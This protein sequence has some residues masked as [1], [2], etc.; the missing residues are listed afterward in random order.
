MQAKSN[1]EE[2]QKSIAHSF[3]GLQFGRTG[4]QTFIC[5]RQDMDAYIS[6]KIRNLSLLLMVLV[7]FIHGYNINLRFTDGSVEAAYSLRFFEGF[8]S[9]GICRVAVPM[10]FAISGFLATVSLG[11]TFHWKGY[12]TLLGKRIKSLLIPYLLVSALGIITVW[13]LLVIPFSKPF[14]NNYS[15]EYTPWKRWI[16]I[17]TLSPVPYPLWF[18]R[19]LMD[20]FLCFPILFFLI[21]LTKGWIL[22]PLAGLW[23]Y[24]Q[25]HIHLTWIKPF[26]TLAPF[27]LCLI[28]GTPFS[29][30]MVASKTEL[31]GLFFFAL[32]IAAALGPASRVS[33]QM[34][35]L[36]FWVLFMA[37]IGWVA[38][39]TSLSL[40]PTRDHYQVHYHLVGFT[41]IG[42]FIFWFLYDQ[43]HG[44]FIRDK[45]LSKAA[46]FS[47]GLFLFHEP[48][49]TI[50]KKGMIRFGGGGDGI[51]W[52]AFLIC[53]ILS[54]LFSFYLSFFLSR[55][56]PTAYNWL[57]G[58]RRPDHQKTPI[59]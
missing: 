42:F 3:F 13:I 22:I 58:N 27:G 4:F 26:F 16:W 14:F 28:S 11:K 53:P 10:F 36:Y 29:M 1:H 21:R 56:V 54:L 43:I 30:Y 19:F 59:S 44:L 40:L 34:P 47:V 49:L 41:F 24:A 50:L 17:W 39:R 2:F 9:D 6:Q 31:E 37:W 45:S 25:I 52:L 23:A 12:G 18:M 46:A 20:Y 5:T 57:T 55:K 38:Y 32:G 48:F 35:R 8:I 33:F 51:L 7:A 15:L